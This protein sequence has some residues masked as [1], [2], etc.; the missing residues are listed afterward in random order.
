MSRGL[1]SGTITAVS[2]NVVRPAIFL[3]AEF[4]DGVVR[5]WNG[6]GSI[7]WDGQTWL[8]LVQPG[9]E[10]LGTISTISEDSTMTAQGINISLS[11][12]DPT[13]LAHALSNIQQG[14]ACRVWVNV[15]D[16]SLNVI[17][18]ALSYAGLI[19]QPTIEEGAEKCTITV[20]VE[21][22]LSDLQRAPMPR[23]TDQQQRLRYPTDD[24]FKF[25]QTLQLWAA[26][27]GG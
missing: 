8:G 11:G 16:S 4:L 24:G 13:M 1:D 7:S 12:V 3:Y 25:V 23:W 17:G 15:F 5:V 19:D 2:A 27:F 18:S 9:G 10:C 14:K 20:S 22:R 26:V 21:S 6:Y